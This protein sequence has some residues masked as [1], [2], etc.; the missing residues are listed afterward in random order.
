MT[1]P[2]V[3]GNWKMNT[4]VQQARQL[5]EEICS[6]VCERTSDTHKTIV[7]C[8]PFVNLSAVGEVIGDRP[9][10]LGA[11]NCWSEPYGAFTGEI[12]TAMLRAVG[13]RYV[14]VGHSERRTIFGEDDQ[15]IA[16]KL[17]RAWEEE[18]VPVLC[19]GETLAERQMHW[20]WSVLS[21]QLELVSTHGHRSS[22]WICAYEPVWAIGTGIAATAE[23]I[24]QAHAYLRSYLD[25]RGCQ[26]VPLLYGGSV[27][28]ENAAEIAAIPYVDGVLVG[29]AS[30][31][32]ER[33]LRI[34]EA[35][36]N[37]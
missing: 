30:L 25:A 17:E 13:C 28:D 29:G 4:T 8:P 31:V 11:Q 9:I 14:I 16:R 37:A 34:I 18:L 20:T 32:A 6:H 7:L 23:E 19:I 27:T 10:A 22:S 35:Q 36:T 26:H 24:E 21:R 1:T 12:S 3:I 2:I 33:F 15:L 5:A